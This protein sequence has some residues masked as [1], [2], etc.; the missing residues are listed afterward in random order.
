M[1]HAVWALALIVVACGGGTGSDE[2]PAPTV[3]GDRV[4]IAAGAPQL[5][6]LRSEAARPRTAAVRRYSGRLAWDDDVTVRMY[7]PVA[8]R[9]LEVKAGVG[10]HITPGQ[11][12]AVISAPDYGQAQ[13]DARD[14]EGAVELAQRTLARA[15]DL[16]EHGAGPKKDVD[17]AEEDM[18]RARAEQQRTQARLRLYGGADATV[19]E[20]LRLRSPIGGTVAERSVAVGQEVRPDQ[21]MASDAPAGK[22]LFVITD[23]TRLWVWLDVSEVDLATL[24][25]GE[26]FTLGTSAY[27]DRHFDGRVDLVGA[28]LDPATRTVRVRG[29]VANPDGALKAEMYV[30]AKV[31][32]T[33]GQPA[34][35]E[36]P[37]KALFLD[38]D[39]RWVF[40]EE[41]PGRFRRQAVQ[42][43]PEHEGWI[44]VTDGVTAG[45]RVVTEGS[46]LLQQVL[47]S[48]AKH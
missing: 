18:A 9:V 40:V 30:T 11:I 39:T 7:P 27:P 29:S 33:D 24:K 17:A 37:A 45:Q 46:L 23:P 10:E 43:G 42:V 32:D 19:D 2:P 1:K 22:P 25:P 16:Y 6:A 8:G 31:T 15:R 5:E 36:V 44:A 41:A 38:G 35:V 21:M 12:L 20:L 48:A 47:D 28:S 34:G 13:A 3:E 4:T 26:T 14:A